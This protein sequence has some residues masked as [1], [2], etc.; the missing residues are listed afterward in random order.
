MKP[1]GIL[2]QEQPSIPCSQ[3]GDVCEATQ[4]PPLATPRG[5]LKDAVEVPRADGMTPPWEMV[6]TRGSSLPTGFGLQKEGNDQGLVKVQMKHQQ[7]WE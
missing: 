3:P 4:F 7:T 1:D 6:E 2:C 5:N